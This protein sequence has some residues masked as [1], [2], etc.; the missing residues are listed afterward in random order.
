MSSPPSCI[1]VNIFVVVVV[2]LAL[3]WLN[4]R[5]ELRTTT[6]VPDVMLVKFLN[7]TL[8]SLPPEPAHCKSTPP[9]QLTSCC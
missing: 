7:V 6:L 4:I 9:W 5:P 2:S 3:T 1:S 8:V